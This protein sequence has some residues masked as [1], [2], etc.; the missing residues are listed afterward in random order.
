ML[1]QLGRWDD[2]FHRSAGVGVIRKIPVSR[3][4]VGETDQ[5]RMRRIAEEQGGVTQDS[6]FTPNAARRADTRFFDTYYGT[7]PPRSVW[8]DHVPGQ[9]FGSGLAAWA[10]QNKGILIGGGIAA[11]A[12][13]FLMDRPKR[14]KNVR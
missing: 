1:I 11:L 8:G 4:G 5:E 13:I 7:T 10:Q 3:A 14:R 2:N 6:Y 12:L 9:P